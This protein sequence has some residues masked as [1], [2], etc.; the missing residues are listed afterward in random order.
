MF[1]V[2]QLQSK[3]IKKKFSS[4]RKHTLQHNYLSTQ[5]TSQF[6]LEHLE[7]KSHLWDGFKLFLFGVVHQI[8]AIE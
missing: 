8:I 2:P 5:N 1:V 4:N 3:K 7:L 6:Q